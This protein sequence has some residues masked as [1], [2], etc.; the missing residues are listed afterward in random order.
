MILNSITYEIKQDGT[1]DFT[2]IQ[3]GIN[4]ANT[5]D[6]LLVYPG[7][8]YENINYNSKDIIIT[9]LYEQ[10]QNPRVPVCPAPLWLSLHNWYHN[11]R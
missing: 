2:T 10:T 6:T 7:T 4:I 5:F 3:A 8:Y 9:S 1:S 11:N